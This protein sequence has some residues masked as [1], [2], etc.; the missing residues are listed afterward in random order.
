MKRPLVSVLI[1]M[2]NHARYI[3]R[4]LDSLLEDGWDNL[5]ALVIDDGSSDESFEIALDW[6]NKHS[7][8]LVRFELTRQE[9]QGL[10][11]TLNKLVEK[12]KGEYVA[13]LASDDYLLP[14][15][16]EARVKALENNPNWLAVIGDVHIV[17]TSGN[18]LHTSGL[19]GFVKRPKWVL[20]HQKTLRRELLLRWWCPGPAL[21]L[22]RC[23]FDSEQIGLYD[24]SISIEDRDYYLKLISR[25]GLGFIHY[26]VAAYRIDLARLSAP[27]PINIL[28]DE[29]VSERRNVVLFSPVEQVLLGIR[30]IRT[31]TKIAFRKEPGSLANNLRLLC[32]N[33]LWALALLYHRLYLYSI[34]MSRR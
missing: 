19:I 4:C 2:Y 1:P 33:V 30:S 7:A 18:L 8:K 14:G 25:N 29:W 3:R 12:A 31:Y 15:G 34:Y 9:N 17:D 23:T 32:T 10:P 24:T 22:R 21:M 11:R 5:E 27:V 20:D 6:A 16:I 28:K 13:L 26:P